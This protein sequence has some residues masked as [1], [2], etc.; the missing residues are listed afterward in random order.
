MEGVLAA[1]APDTPCVSSAPPPIHLPIRSANREE[2]IWTAL[3]SVHPAKAGT[4]ALA[5]QPVLD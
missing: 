4:Q 2:T 1:H 5:A 3:S